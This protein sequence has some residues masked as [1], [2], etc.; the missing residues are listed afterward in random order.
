[1]NLNKKI[2]FVVLI[3]VTIMGMSVTAFAAEL[4]SGDVEWENATIT[5][6]DIYNGAA[7]YIGMVGGDTPSVNM[8]YYKMGN[9]YNMMYYNGGFFRNIPTPKNIKSVYFSDRYSDSPVL[10]VYLT[11]GDFIV[12][13]TQFIDS[14]SNGISNHVIGGSQ[15]ESDIADYSIGAYFNV[16]DHVGE[17]TFETSIVEK[18]LTFGAYPAWIFSKPSTEW[19]MSENKGIQSLGFYLYDTDGSTLN[20]DL[21]IVNLRIMADQGGYTPSFG[22]AF[23]DDGTIYDISGMWNESAVEITQQ[24]P[25]SI[26]LFAGATEWNTKGVPCFIGS[27]G[28]YRLNKDT[29]DGYEKITDAHGYTFVSAERKGNLYKATLDDNGT[30]V[31]EYYVNG[32]YLPCPPDLDLDI[33]TFTDFY[34][35]QEKFNGAILSYNGNYIEYD[36]QYNVKKV[37]TLNDGETASIVSFGDMSGKL[38]VE[39]GPANNESGSI[40][41]YYQHNGVDLIPSD[42]WSLAPDDYT[43]RAPSISG[44]TPSAASYTATITDGMNANYTFDYVPVVA[45]DAEVGTIKIYYKANG[46]DVIPFDT[47]TLAPSDYI[48]RAPSLSGHAPTVA[49]YTATITDGMDASY[50]FNYNPV[51]PT[52]ITNTVTQTVTQTVPVEVIKEV[53]VEKPIRVEVEKY[54]ASTREVVIRDELLALA[55]IFIKFYDVLPQYWFYE[56]IRKAATRQIVKGY[57]DN[58]F[59]PYQNVNE[60]ELLAMLLR[61][62]GF[63]PTADSNYWSDAYYKRY[64]SGTTFG[65]KTT[66]NREQTAYF[67][68]KFL[69][70]TWDGVEKKIVPDIDT[71]HPY[72]QDAVQLLYAKGIIVG[73]N[74]QGDFAPLELL[75]RAQVATIIDRATR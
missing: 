72:F 19:L 24:T 62:Q 58:S 31:Y 65:K 25:E 60:E 39:T 23:G 11:T 50:T 55:P 68:V 18:P 21:K 14:F 17:I 26:A 40:N 64:G 34:Q 48:F 51:A 4:G 46:V 59:K 73:V 2:M 74:K 57:D 29:D 56:P 70:L 53:I 47:W 75:N 6:S 67:I 54:R 71:V 49:S 69:G 3:L 12:Y 35:Y 27:D 28:I 5:S 15:L 9:D 41:I 52:V 32:E 22:Y 33:E 63:M 43:F 36:S 13:R 16:E 42:T 38:V 30:P 10:F 61:S 44:Y 20:P 7:E 45:P 66:L 37:Y 8:Y 1:M